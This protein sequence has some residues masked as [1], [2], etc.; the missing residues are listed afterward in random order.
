MERYQVKLESFE[1]PLDLLLHLVQQAE[2]DLYDIPV[3][4]ITAQYMTYIHAMQQLELDVASEYLV[5]ASSLLAIKSKMLL[6]TPELVNEDEEWEEWEEEDPREELAM[7]LDLYRKYKEAANFLQEQ[8][9][10]RAKR[11]SKSPTDLEQYKDYTEVQ[12]VD[13]D[14]DATVTDL[15]QAFQKMKQR[16]RMRSPKHTTVEQERHSIEE[17]MTVIT[18]VLAGQN[19]PVS[20]QQA[21]AIGEMDRQVTTFIALLQLVKDGDVSCEQEENFEDIWIQ[22]KGMSVH[23]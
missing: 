22:A 4:E 18:D 17:R 16:V 12:E 7:Q 20:F 5:M 1:G 15:I 14:V 10:H 23:A 11:Y 6:P 13:E 2:V 3:A 19:S 9:D 8:S 21:F